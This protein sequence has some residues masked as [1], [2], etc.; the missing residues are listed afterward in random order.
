MKYVDKICGEFRTLSSSL[1]SESPIPLN[2]FSPSSVPCHNILGISI[3]N[4]VFG[5]K[6]KYVK[7]A[8]K[9]LPKRIALLNLF[10]DLFLSLFNK[11]FSTVF[12]VN[13]RFMWLQKFLFLFFCKQG[14]MWVCDHNLILYDSLWPGN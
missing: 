11:S 3:T 14:G 9:N 1:K 6:T 10:S 8:R 2:S 12:F 13:S 7:E 5:N 4:L